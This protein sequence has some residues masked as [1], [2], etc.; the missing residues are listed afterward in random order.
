MAQRRLNKT[1]KILKADNR[2]VG[3]LLFYN[4]FLTF[5]A[6]KLYNPFTVVHKKVELYSYLSDIIYVYKASWKQ[7]GEFC[8]EVLCSVM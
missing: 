1:V 7:F 2:L 6:P 4:N 3:Y 8:A 5:K